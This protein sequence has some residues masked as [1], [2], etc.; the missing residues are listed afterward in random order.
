[1]R[2]AHS[3][4]PRSGRSGSVSRRSR[5]GFSLLELMVVL[6]LIGIV[7]ATAGVRVGAMMTQQRVTRAA[8]MIQSD[9]ELAFALAG[10]NRKPMRLT[11]TA[12]ASQ[13]TFR[14]TDRTGAIVYKSTDFKSSSFGLS[15]GQVTASSN[16]VEVYPNGFASDTLAIQISVTRNSQPYT[17]RIRM[18]RAGLVKVM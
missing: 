6:V 2:S 3:F 11:W 18:S 13:M 16:L 14:V 15:L 10:R 9:M 4:G 8:G 12:N 17:K 1:M 7:T 5:R